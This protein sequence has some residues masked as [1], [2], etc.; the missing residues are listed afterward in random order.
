MSLTSDLANEIARALQEYSS[1]VEDEIDSIAEEVVTKAVQELKATSPKRFG[2]Y[3]KNWRFK[4]NSKGSYVIHNADP[5]FRLT[6]LLENGHVL[7]NGGRSKA[8]PHIKPV[9]EK[10]KEQF[11]KKVKNIGR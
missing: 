9:E 11:E 4:K 2:K 8:I 3:A 5:T 10:V 7:R 6:H 1:E